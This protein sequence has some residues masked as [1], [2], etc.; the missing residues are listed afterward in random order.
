MIY[1]NGAQI[2]NQRL[3]EDGVTYVRFA[4]SARDLEQM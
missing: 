1:V 4:Q 3:I 2:Q